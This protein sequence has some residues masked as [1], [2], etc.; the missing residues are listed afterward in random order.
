MSAGAVRQ[1]RVFVEIGADPK[2][3]FAALASVNKRIGSIGR[4]MQQMGTRMVGIGAA[5][6]VP[7][8]MATRQLAAFDDAI[9]ATAAVSGASGEAL[10]RMNDQ[11]RELGRT[12]SFTAV[13]V[14][15]L[16]TELGRAGFRPDEIKF[17][18]A[19]VL[20][21]ARA[22]G[23]EASMAAGIMAATLRQFGL[24]AINAGRA[25][26]VLTKAANSTFNTVEK[27]GDSLK[28][29]GPVAKDLGLSLEDTVAIL[30]V[31]GNVGIQG[32][33]AGTALRR[34]GVI[35]AASGEKLQELFGV[36]NTDAEGNLKPLIQ[37]LDE[38]NT[39][40][41]QMTVADRTAKMEQAFGLL[42]ITS[43]SVLSKSAGGVQELAD[44]LR[45]AEGTAA[46]TAKQM[47]A[48]LG[49]SLRIL[50][51]AVE[52]VALAFGDALAPSFQQ[53]AALAIKS[54][55]ALTGWVNANQEAIVSAMKGAAAFVAVGGAF[56]GIGGSLRLV[57]FGLGGLTS[58]LSLVVV[59]MVGVVKAA[60]AIV[61]GFVA[62]TVKVAAYTAVSL[63]GAAATS[64]AWALAHAPLIALI[65]LVGGLIAA[66]A[67]AAGGFRRLGSEARAGFSRIASDAANVFG[68]FKAIAGST[69][70]AI[71]DAISGGD[72]AAAMEIAMAGMLAAFARGAAAIK[73]EMGGM[74]AF[75]LNTLDAMRSY[76]RQPLMLFPD[77]KDPLVEAD[78]EALR[79]RQDQRINQANSSGDSDRR[80][81]ANA[82]ARVND[83]AQSIRAR[84]VNREQV[85]E[86]ISQ[87]T[88][89]KTEDVI[90]DL[91]DQLQSLADN[92]RATSEQQSRFAEAV[93]EARERI[94]LQAQ[95]DLLEKE[96]RAVVKPQE[97]PKPDGVKVQSEA[98][99]TFSSFALSSLGVGQTIQQKILDA[100]IRTADAVEEMAAAGP[101]VAMD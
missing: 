22:T 32:T 96:I 46:E 8:A 23:T 50:L 13:Q 89:A 74:Q 72:M 37:V 80:I 33:N 5:L 90:A 61:A 73:G 49:G 71:T 47:D 91:S 66:A 28:Y 76:A 65:G 17:M 67:S 94:A 4:S 99:G 21:L 3:L 25:A 54:A 55:G 16:M 14:A 36:S 60:M 2:K 84:R 78:R 34:L 77:I 53:L 86:V 83:L 12:T 7:V 59:P 26:D 19:A 38:I 51:S 27:L 20:D 101:M 45:A 11:A 70:S 41:A 9:R 62:A 29:A 44:S 39:A 69:L 68:D 100:S 10:Q 75:I 63:A 48:G 35:S 56:V 64:A 85:E 82:A 93:K 92:G 24:G 6:A 40:T 98:A 31:L 95:Q 57:A 52:G 30:G 18:T 1:G 42:G 81:A 87:A 43:A 79:Q 15:N 58:A 97:Q 88:K